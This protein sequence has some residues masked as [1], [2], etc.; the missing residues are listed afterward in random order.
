[1][2]FSDAPG[3]RHQLVAHAQEVLADDVEIGVGQ[4]V[5]DVGDAA[6]DGVL[7][8]DHGEPRFARL[9][10]LQRVLER[11]AGDRVEVGIRLAAGEVGI[12]ARLALVDDALSGG[13]G[14]RGIMRLEPFGLAANTSS[15][16][17][18]A[19]L[20]PYRRGTASRPASP[21]LR[22]ARRWYRC[23]LKIA[24]DSRC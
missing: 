21:G 5:M 7:D 1:M 17:V 22:R 18:G 16:S 2:V 3:R 15:G 11:R 24:R 10:R 14:H 20:C 4:Q 19:V 13:F 23:A 6:G 12:S 9:H 8:G